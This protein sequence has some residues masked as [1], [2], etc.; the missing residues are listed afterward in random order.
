MGGLQ[1][2]TFDT[3]TDISTQLWQLPRVRVGLGVTASGWA[4][5]VERAA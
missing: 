2:L 4:A 1:D 5:F 3:A